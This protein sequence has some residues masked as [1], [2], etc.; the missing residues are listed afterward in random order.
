MRTVQR[1][2]VLSRIISRFLGRRGKNSGYLG[3]ENRF[4]WRHST[5]PVMNI[6]ALNKILVQNVALFQSL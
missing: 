3:C 1:R 2:G 4:L 6:D 5:S